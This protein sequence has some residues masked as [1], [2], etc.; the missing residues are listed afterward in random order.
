MN[1]KIAITLLAVALP[2]A[3]AA[4]S[5]EKGPDHFGHHRGDRV[6]RLAKELDLNADQ[7][8]KLEDI[9]KQEHEKFEALRQETHQQ[10][11]GVLT[12]EQMTKF[13]QLKKERHEKWRK[14][15]EERKQQQSESSD[16]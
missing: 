16:D 7:K 6:E 4:S 15:H 14:R 12:P 3:V 10:I 8:T 5:G 11:Q 9:F 2:L 1:K 13:E